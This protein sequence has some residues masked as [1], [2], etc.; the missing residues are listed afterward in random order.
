M[1]NSMTIKFIPLLLIFVACKNDIDN[2]VNDK[3]LQ[4]EIDYILGN[5][6]SRISSTDGRLKEKEKNNSI[7]YNYKGD[8]ITFSFNI[9]PQ[10]SDDLKKIDNQIFS[11]GIFGH[12]FQNRNLKES[13]LTMEKYVDLLINDSAVISGELLNYKKNREE[14][15]AK[16]SD[17]TSFDIVDS[18]DFE[19]KKIIENRK[20]YKEKF[21]K[22][23]ELFKQNNYNVFYDEF[24]KLKVLVNLT[25]SRDNL[26]LKQEFNEFERLYFIDGFI[27]IPGKP[28][29]IL[30][31]KLT[32]MQKKYINSIYNN[33][34]I[35]NNN[36][37]K[38]FLY[39]NFLLNLYE[40]N[41][42]Y[43]IYSS[44]KKEINYEL[45][46]NDK[47]KE[48]L[49]LFYNEKDIDLD[50]LYAEFK[51]NVYNFEKSNDISEIK[52]V[53]ENLKKITERILL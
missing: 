12:S 15:Y 41:L 50:L 16:N 49:K 19:N 14:N 33:L 26:I 34:V 17:S 44:S 40:N 48:I 30:K 1:K 6:L 38:D 3:N 39:I 42:V 31:N 36:L 47:L 46:K 45:L 13:E 37:Y 32:D 27:K 51:N 25:E 18:K 7:S 8:F 22:L 43:K 24:Y 9:N 23:K 21:I 10:N 5:Q 28:V 20:D 29:P 11:K 35:N 2:E 53:K 52:S 4:K